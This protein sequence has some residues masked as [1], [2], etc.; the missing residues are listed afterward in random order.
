MNVQELKDW[1]EQINKRTNAEF[2]ISGVEDKNIFKVRNL[3]REGIIH[4]CEIIIQNTKK[5]NAFLEDIKDMLKTLAV[6][7]VTVKTEE[8]KPE[9]QPEPATAKAEPVS[10]KPWMKK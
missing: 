5:T 9:P 2:V 3:L 6:Y 4:R 1:A 10:E 7:N 8:K